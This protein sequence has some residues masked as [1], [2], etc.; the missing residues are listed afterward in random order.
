MG[1]EFIRQPGAWAS[2]P[3]DKNMFTYIF[4]K[5]A[6]WGMNMYEQDWL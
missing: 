6:K 3:I 4:T 2:M 1:Y 5:A